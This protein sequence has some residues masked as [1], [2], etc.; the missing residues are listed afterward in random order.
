MKLRLC[1]FYQEFSDV[2]LFY[3]GFVCRTFNVSYEICDNV[4]LV[5]L[6]LNLPVLLHDPGHVQT[7]T[8]TGAKVP[9][10]EKDFIVQSLLCPSAQLNHR[11]GYT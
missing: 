8:L 2:S 7:M 3:G 9:W 10:K 4:S 5:I 11:L 6:L 1:I